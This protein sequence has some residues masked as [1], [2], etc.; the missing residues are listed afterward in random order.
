MVHATDSPTPHKVTDAPS[1]FLI[2]PTEDDADA[3]RSINDLSADRSLRQPY[4]ELNLDHN[5]LVGPE[6]IREVI[7]MILDHRPEDGS[8]RIAMFDLTN[9]KVIDAL[10]RALSRGVRIYMIMDKGQYSNIRSNAR[11][12]TLE[13]I[14]KLNQYPNLLLAVATGHGSWVKDVSFSKP[15]TCRQASPCSGMSKNPTFA[16]ATGC[17]FPEG[18]VG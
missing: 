15:G 2:G 9:T 17:R 3:L 11:S 18:F 6:A 8:L 14:H 5:I 1:P 13:R 12:R 10:D 4:T 16:S 7:Q